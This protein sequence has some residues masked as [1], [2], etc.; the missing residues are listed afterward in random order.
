MAASQG[1]PSYRRFRLGKEGSHA[2][3]DGAG[4]ASP[5]SRESIRISERDKMSDNKRKMNLNRVPN[6]E[7]TSR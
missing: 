1:A 2:E 4:K 5:K 6:R 3:G 7:A